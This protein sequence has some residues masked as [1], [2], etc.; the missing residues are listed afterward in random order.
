MPKKVQPDEL[1]RALDDLL[2]EY[3]DEI[4]ESAEEVTKKCAAIGV[5]ALKANSPRKKKGGGGYAS[6][7]TSKTEKDRVTTTVV[8]YNGKKPGL[9]HLLENG[10]AVISTDGDHVGDAAAHVHIAPVEKE[11]IERFEREIKME[12]SR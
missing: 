10:H 8:I 6:G 11:L 4:I 2:N 9:A 7:W 5:K 3:K 12:V 1:A